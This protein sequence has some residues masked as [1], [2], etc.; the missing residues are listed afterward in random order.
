[1]CRFCF[2]GSVGSARAAIVPGPVP[3]A[4]GFLALQESPKI[5]RFPNFWF[6]PNSRKSCLE[7]NLAL[8]WPSKVPKARTAVSADQSLMCNGLS[9]RL[10]SF[11]CVPRDHW[12]SKNNGNW[13]F[14][15]SLSVQKTQKT[16]SY[17]KKKSSDTWNLV[18]SII[19]NLGNPPRELKLSRPSELRYA[20][21]KTLPRMGIFFAR[22]PP[23][24]TGTCSRQMRSLKTRTH[25]RHALA[26]AVEYTALGTGVRAEARPIAHFWIIIPHAAFIVGEELLSKYYF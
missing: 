24:R 16:F 15:K 19:R 23:R 3:G 12:I 14:Q 10:P 9:W 18:K 4:Q 21:Q 8:C 20:E 25:P 6:S 17:T 13:D 2:W 26:R 5:F 1:M 7:A 11:S 22:Q